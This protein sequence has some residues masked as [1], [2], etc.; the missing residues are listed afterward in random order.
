M[1]AAPY[2]GL[3]RNPGSEQSTVQLGGEDCWGRSSAGLP[4]TF[5]ASEERGDGEERGAGRCLWDHG[6]LVRQLKLCGL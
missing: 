4:G 1:A 3:E 5:A 6:G 2:G